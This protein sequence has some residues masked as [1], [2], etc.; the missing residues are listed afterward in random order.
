VVRWMGWAGD[1]LVGWTATEAASDQLKQ[2]IC[3]H[4]TCDQASSKPPLVMR[5]GMR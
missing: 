4:L 2:H 1:G 3:V 5:Q